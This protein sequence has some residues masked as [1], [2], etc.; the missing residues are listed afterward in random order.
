MRGLNLLGN[1][2]DIQTV[3]YVLKT[4]ISIGLQSTEARELKSNL[5]KFGWVG[6]QKKKAKKKRGGE[7]IK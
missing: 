4:E 1:E 7:E 2:L 3:W 5:L 6:T